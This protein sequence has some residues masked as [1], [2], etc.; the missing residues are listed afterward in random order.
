MS[1]AGHTKVYGS[2]TPTVRVVLVDDNDFPATGFIREGDCW[3]TSTDANVDVSMSM[4][5]TAERI[6]RRSGILPDQEKTEK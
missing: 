3:A 4:T 1:E 5:T 6:V 2:G